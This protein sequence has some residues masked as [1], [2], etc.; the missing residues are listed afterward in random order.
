VWEVR[1]VRV[2]SG[3]SELCRRLAF[4]VSREHLSIMAY[5][6]LVDISQQGNTNRSFIEAP[7]ASI[8]SVNVARD[9]NN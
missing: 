4:L 9:V 6:D 5:G 8:A 2:V 7:K 1:G 3:M